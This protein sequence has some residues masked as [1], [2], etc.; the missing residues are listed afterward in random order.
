MRVG[1]LSGLG[2]VYGSDGSPILEDE[3][4][5]VCEASGDNILVL[6]G[7]GRLRSET[8]LDHTKEKGT[9]YLTNRRLIFLRTPDEWKKLYTYGNPLGTATAFSEASY[10]QE[11]KDKG[12]MEYLELQYEEVK[13]FRGK[14][15]KWT[16]LY[17]QDSEG[18]KVEVLLARRDRKDDKLVVLEELLLKAGAEKLN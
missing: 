8:I 4:R 18:V 13:A 10:A 16:N 17:L 3:E 11:L 14:K 1:N 2:S 5:V 6:R 9:L 15:G 7:E 12:G